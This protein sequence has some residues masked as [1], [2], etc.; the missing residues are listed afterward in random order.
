MLYTFES[1][2]AE[3]THKTQYF[4]ITGNRAVYSDGLFMP[5]AI[6]RRTLGIPAPHH[7]AKRQVGALRHPQRLP[8]LTNDLAASIPPSSR[9]SRTFSCRKRSSTVSCPS[10]T[11]VA[12]RFNAALVGPPRPDVG[13]HLPPPS[14]QGMTG[15]PGENVFINIKNRSMPLHHRR[16]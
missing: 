3:S 13:P 4:E 6:C 16:P 1:P 15:A 14:S 8:A 7:A 5:A 12:E 10:T 2:K 11:A 9:S